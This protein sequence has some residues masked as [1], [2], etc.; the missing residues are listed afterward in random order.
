MSD[1][2]NLDEVYAIAVQI[3]S[4]GED[5]YRLAAQ[6]HAKGET[7]DLLN[8]MAVME[9]GHKQTFE[10]LRAA[11]ARRPAPATELLLDGSLYMAAIADGFRLEGSPSVAEE[12]TGRETI[13]EMLRLALELEKQSVL[14]YLGLKDIA[15]HS[16]RDAI[17]GII[18]EE[19]R[20]IATLG[21]ELKSRKK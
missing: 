9:A 5:F 13:E 21:Q 2:F 10:Q 11:A 3:E 15:P 8:R 18:E 1:L 19:K 6:R 16:A 20:H 17:Q 12:L 7:A 14:F 4:H